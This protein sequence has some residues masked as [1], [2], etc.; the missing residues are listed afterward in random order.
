MAYKVKSTPRPHINKD[1]SKSYTKLDHHVT[2]RHRK[3]K[4]TLAIVSSAKVAD[5][6]VKEEKA[7]HFGTDQ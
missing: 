5:E 2:V 4:K 6:L 7:R 3:I 1:G